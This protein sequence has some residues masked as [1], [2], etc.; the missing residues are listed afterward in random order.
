M[1]RL[2]EECLADLNNLA[3]GLRSRFCLS[4]FSNSLR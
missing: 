2:L 1:F 3:S 4:L